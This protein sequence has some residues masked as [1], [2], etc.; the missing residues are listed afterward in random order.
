MDE[1]QTNQAAMAE[2][3]G[4]QENGDAGLDLGGVGKTASQWAHTLTK[5]VKSVVVLKVVRPSSYFRLT[6][7]PSALLTPS[8]QTQTRAFD[9]ESAGSSYATGFI[10]DKK[11]GLILTNRHVITPGPIVAEAVFH[12]REEVKV[13]PLYYDPVHDFG[14]F[15]FDPTALK[16]MQ[17]E[18]VPLAPEAA[19]VGLDIRV[20]GNDSGE[21]ISILSGTLAR[22]DRDAPHY[23]RRH[24]NDFNTFYLQAASGT[25]GGSSGS[26]VVDIQG[27]AVAL[28]AG[29]KNKAASAYYLPLERVVRA[30]KI[31]QNCCTC[32]TGG[33]ASSQTNTWV[34]PVIPRG[35]LQTT[36]LFKG[37]DE[38]KRLGLREETETEVRRAQAQAQRAGDDGDEEKSNTNLFSASAL[39]RRPSGMLVV[40]SVV[41]GGPGDAA[42]LE[43]GDVLIR[44][45]GGIVTD[46]LTM[47]TLLDDKIASITTSSSNKAA[48]QVHLER[49]GVEIVTT[50]TI[51]N[52][53]SVTPTRL[54]ELGGGT[55]NELSYQQARNNRSP[56]GQVYVAEPGY[57]L[58]K[59]GC[60]KHA[61]ITAV[62]GILT[63]T[64]DAFIAVLLT[65]HHGERVPME[66]FTFDDRHR[67][68]Q[69]ILMMDFNW[70]GAPVEWRRDD[71]LGVWTSTTLH[72][73]TA[74]ISNALKE[75]KKEP[76][77]PRLTSPRAQGL[78]A[79]TSTLSEKASPPAAA[80]TTTTTTTT[81]TTMRVAT[82]LAMPRRHSV[83]DVATSM[84]GVE[85]T[86]AGVTAQ[87]EDHRLQT[88]HTMTTGDTNTAQPITTTTTNEAWRSELEARLRSAMVA[89][90]VEIPLVALAD[91][92]H[93]RAFSG[94]G[95]V[96]HL[97]PRL[98]LVV[99]DRN[100]VTIG[101]GDIMMSFGA[102]PAEIS[103]KVRFLHPLHNFS[104]LSFDPGD[105]SQDASSLVSAV[106]LKPSPPLHRGD[107]V[108]LVGLS[109]ALRILHRTSTVT[110]PALSVGIAQADVPRF[111]A[112]YEDV[113]KIE[114]DFGVLYSGVL[115]DRSG[116]VRALWGSFSEQAEKE[117]REWTAGLPTAVFA[118]WVEKMVAVLDPPLLSLPSLPSPAQQEQ[119]KHQKQK[120]PHRGVGLPPCVRVL[121]AD[122]EPLL[123]SKAAQFGL[124][125]EWVAKL[126]ALDPERR[127]VLRVRST[128]AGSSAQK[129]LKD[130]DMVLEVQGKA[131]SCFWDVE[132]LCDESLQGGGCTTTCCQDQ[133]Q[134]GEH[135]TSAPDPKRQRH[136]TSSS[137]TTNTVLVTVF[138]Q[139]EVLPNLGVTLGVEDGLGT[140]RL[141]HWA[142]CQL[143][144]PHRGVRELG[145]LP[146]G[147]SGVYISRWHHGSPA[148]RYGIYAL[149]WIVEVDGMKIPDLDAFL[150]A[151]K[152]LKDGE[153]VRLKIVHFETTK[154]RV[155]TLKADLRYWPT[156]ELRLDGQRGEWTRV[157]T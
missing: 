151:V 39:A 153:D 134:G 102:W 13:L 80:A 49:G 88:T 1:D 5:I 142:G 31:L 150:D 101:C 65:L 59:A 14:F 126:M 100:T 139:G 15:R 6:C 50:T 109:K 32:S 55:V 92:V 149:H 99:V 68:K 78:C 146:P 8:L 89:V 63:P 72:P 96:V 27:R 90:D 71:S 70:Y 10:V 51:Q 114:Q 34:A 3:L 58:G 19:A 48:V 53:S 132:Q 79:S 86:Q 36:F 93:S 44:L 52:L 144:A 81:T 46:F 133:D 37:F 125:G 116:A 147:A 105:L 131:V 103:A 87:V 9:T 64:L 154:P 117:E 115:A 113:V 61:V 110:T 42:G 94:C 148:H 22:L 45:D 2:D 18:E 129:V 122:L 128:V 28:N 62:R 107:T 140:D 41:P 136:D 24:F 121:D 97:S 74:T 120:L 57:L 12:N 35:D 82:M 91:G 127:Q 54:L 20:V 130:G 69:A 17:V 33:D 124:P 106:T 152:C 67:R 56:V 157:E 76:M 135:A 47:E 29:G 77:S 75:E 16:F 83:Q 138:R 95:I 73:I 156:W 145:F 137:T 85:K 98:G 108:E 123:L 111:R 25:K 104:I 84:D 11:L 7:R 4:G 26:P 60:P 119:H 118:P 40:D 143:Q 43:P 112:T 30:L 141:V 38:V 66:F 155:L 21:K 23:G